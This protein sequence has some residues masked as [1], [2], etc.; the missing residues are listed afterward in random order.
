MF[1]FY[2]QDTAGLYVYDLG[3]ALLDACTSWYNGK[4]VS[5][6]QAPSVFAPRIVS[7][8]TTALGAFFH[9]FFQLY[10]GKTWQ[11]ESACF[12]LKTNIFAGRFP[13]QVC[14]VENFK[15]RDKQLN[16]KIVFLNY[17]SVVMIFREYFLVL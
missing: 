16:Y 3:Y 1:N 10:T 9:P 14:F 5:N 2:Y 8:P 13:Q 6:Y 15:I 11:T 4:L 7:C 12:V 17:S